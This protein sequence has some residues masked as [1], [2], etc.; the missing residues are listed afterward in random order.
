LVKARLADLHRQAKELAP[1]FLAVS[2]AEQAA[3][4]AECGR[5]N[6]VVKQVLYESMSASQISDLELI[7]LHV[8]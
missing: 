1:V 7:L 2:S 5:C 6:I 8:G 3:L 4:L